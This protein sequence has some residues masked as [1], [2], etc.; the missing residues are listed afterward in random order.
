MATTEAPASAPVWRFGLLA[1]ASAAATS[2]LVPA[3]PVIAESLALG[4]AAT[5][6]VLSA[7]IVPYAA[8][9]IVAG[10]LCDER[11]PRTVLRVGLVLAVL[12]AV[13]GALSP[14]ALPLLAARAVQG[15]GCGAVT[16]AAY[17]VARRVPN[18]IPSIAALLTLGASIGPLLGGVLAS[19]VGW[20][21]A[22]VLPGLLHLTG[23]WL[24]TTDEP[25]G[26]HGID[27]TGLLLTGVGALLGAAGLQ[28]ARVLP[29]VALP[30]GLLGGA[31]LGAA[32]WRV[33]R[34]GGRVPPRAILTVPPLR[35]NGAQ[36]MT[37][38]ATYFASLVV[39]PVR[40]G[41]AGFDSIVIGALLLP[42]AVIGSLSARFSNRTAAWLGRWTEPA[43]AMVTLLV[44][45]A[46][47]VL[48]PVLAA[49]VT[50]GLA[51][52]YGTIQPRLLADIAAEVD[53]GPATGIGAANLVLLLGGG[54]GSATIGGLG[55]GLGAAVIGTAVVAILLLQLGAALRTSPT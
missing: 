51:W 6:G 8:A 38:A 41:E 47:V 30:L 32:V 3:L 14:S 5:A 11:G 55:T 53:D 28:L 26:G 2:T 35:R 27:R 18:G 20:Q 48:P 10:Q 40:L 36:A 34:H 42:G 29:S 43:A 15:I 44:L 22:V 54:I 37:I 46:I 9:V 12:G 17:D 45:S 24:T 25:G 49:L 13:C 33:L 19:T 50:T 52:S 4:G 23:F 21:A 7:Y 31:V 1:A 16:M 39:I